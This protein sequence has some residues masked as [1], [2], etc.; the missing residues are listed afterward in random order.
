MKKT[1]INPEIVVVPFAATQPIAASITSIGGNS[2]LLL[3]DDDIIPV[4]ADIK[5]LDFNNDIWNNE[6]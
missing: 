6:W 4:S 1:Y 2:E 5:T 3:G